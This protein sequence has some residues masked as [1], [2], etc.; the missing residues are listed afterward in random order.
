MVLPVMAPGDKHHG[1]STARYTT[2]LENVGSFMY[3]AL[4]I[5]L[6]LVLSSIPCP[7]GIYGRGDRFDVASSGPS[8]SK[9]L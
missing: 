2:P 5:T 9:S 7:L 3:R 4:M 6:I 1:K 8:V